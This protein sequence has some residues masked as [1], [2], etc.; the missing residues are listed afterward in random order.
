MI[1]SR[2]VMTA[3]ERKGKPLQYIRGA[4]ASWTGNLLGSLLFAGLFTHLTDILSEEPFR[5]GTISMISEDIIESQWHIIFLRSILCGWLVTFS[6]MLGS[7]NQDGISK[8]LALHL[9]FFISTAAKCPHTVEYMYLGSTAMFLGSPMSVAMF[10]WKCLIPVTLGNTIGG[11]IFT[12]AY[13]WWVHL[14]C[15]DKGVKHGD[16]NGNGWGSVRLD[17]DE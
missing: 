14:Y 1:F 4:I 11:G 6:M 13:S 8:A 17:D 10:I 5:S 9:P 16:A 12:G 2:F 3:L 7:Q 15:D